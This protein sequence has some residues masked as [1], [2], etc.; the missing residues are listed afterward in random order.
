MAVAEQPAA[1]TTIPIHPTTDT[2][3]TTDTMAT[4]ETSSSSIIDI[5]TNNPISPSPWDAIVPID[6]P[7]GMNRTHTID[8]RMCA[9]NMFY[10]KWSWRPVTPRHR[11]HKSTGAEIELFAVRAFAIICPPN[12]NFIYLIITQLIWFILIDRI[13]YSSDDRMWVHLSISLLAHMNEKKKTKH[14]ND[15]QSISIIP[16]R[17]ISFRGVIH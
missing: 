14:K 13:N 6:A 9:S 15:S 7:S 3:T 2:I 8:I 12:A 5:T 10:T 1:T 16:L 11:P 4:I 17:S